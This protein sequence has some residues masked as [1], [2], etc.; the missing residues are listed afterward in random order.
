MKAVLETLIEG[1]LVT[2]K[3]GEAVLTNPAFDK[4]FGAI[5]HPVILSTI[6]EVLKNGVPLKRELILYGDKNP[7][8]FSIQAAPLQEGAVLV[9]HDVTDIKKLEN[10]RR[11]F[12]ANISHEL[13]TPLTNILGYAE[14]LLDGALDDKSVAKEFVEKI[15]NNGRELQNLIEDIFTITASETGK[16]KLNMTTLSLAP[17]LK[18]Q[19]DRHR[20]H[21]EE[22]KLALK[23]NVPQAAH[24]MAD[25]KA[26]EQIVG[27]LL[28][29]AIQYTHPGGEVTLTVRPELQGFWIEVSDTGVGID[30]KDL[31]HIFER[32]Y[33]VEKSRAKGLG[34]TGLGLAI[35]KHLVVAHGG[36]VEAESKPN[37][38]STFKVF[39]P[40]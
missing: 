24:V 28:D 25:K 39:L 27:N 18:E 8:H 31:P 4:T 5:R 19:T 26:L 13:K 23:M 38:G 1:V 17:F 20:L 10:T 30:P 21:L 35:V 7:S 22:K 6:E 34:G 15:A 16:L 37:H 11:E 33:R 36:K 14:T 29:N 12:I 40:S 2:N 3:E 32:F 9:F